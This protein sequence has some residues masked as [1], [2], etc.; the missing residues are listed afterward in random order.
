MSMDKQQYITDEQGNKMAVVVPIDQY[1]K[2]M[3]EIEE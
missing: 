1:E 2:M 3:K